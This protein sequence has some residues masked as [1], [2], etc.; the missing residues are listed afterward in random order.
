[1]KLPNNVIIVKLKYSRLLLDLFLRPLEA[2]ACAAQLALWGRGL[3]ATLFFT[4]LFAL[5]GTFLAIPKIAEEAKT[6]SGYLGQQLGNV[7]LQDGKL[8]WDS[9]LALPHTAHLK[10]LRIDIVDNS[11][12]IGSR[13]LANE[14]ADQGLVIAHD[15][16]ILWSQNSETSE[17]PSHTFIK[18]LSVPRTQENLRSMQKNGVLATTFSPDDLVKNSLFFCYS[19]L[20]VILFLTGSLEKLRVIFF[21]VFFFSFFQMIFRRGNWH[22]LGQIISLGLH[23]CL[24]PLII[25]GIYGLTGFFAFGFE[26]AFWVALLLY[27][28][29]VFIKRKAAQSESAP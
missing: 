26:T 9:G 15:D 12:E 17:G 7:S 13:S 16:I 14:L 18:I 23:A 22:N 6:L 20:P 25:S 21:C 10:N 4:V 1:M 24:P 5:A 3:L 8:D 11:A 19:A 27:M 2:Q 28:F 29:F